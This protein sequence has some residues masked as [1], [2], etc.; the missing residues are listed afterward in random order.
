LVC[1]ALKTASLLDMT[2][3]LPWIAGRVLATALLALSLGAGAQPE[4]LHHYT[5]SI[6]EALSAISVHACFDGKPPLYLVSESLDAAAALDE[7]KADATRKQL[8]PNGAELKLGALP[9]GSC[10]SYRTDLSR[11]SR[12]NERDSEPLRRNGHDLITELGIW[13]WRPQSLEPDE[14]IEV[15]F[16][17]PPGISASAPWRPLVAADGTRAYRV[18]HSPYDWPAKVVFGHFQEMAIQVPG[19]VLRVALLDSSPTVEPDFVRQWL[20]RAATAV[21]TL[22]G[23][24]PVPHAQIV[25][26]PGTRGSEPVPWAYVLRGGAPAAHFFINQRRPLA[27]F[28]TD[29]TAVHELSHMLL[30]YVR[31]EDA[32]LSEGTASYYQNVLR[33]RAGMIPVPEA[34][35]KLH[36]GFRRGMK[37]MP[38]LTL[39]GA[40]ERMF[41]DG[42][43][44]RVYWEGA[45]MMLLADQRLRSRT[46]GAQSLD[47]ALARLHACCLSAATG[48]QARELFVKLDELTQTSVFGELYE[49]YIAS[50]AFPQVAE[51][52]RQLGLALDDE[53]ESIRL[54]DAAPQIAF[55]DAIMRAHRAEN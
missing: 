20:T 14:D 51:A 42:A 9:D 6:D 35:Q 15:R 28:L 34:W 45:A 22:Y 10:V 33:A 31:P 19:A 50:T 47:S 2:R 8:E 24:F 23:E 30:P 44:M 52:Y 54:L 12:R 13:F 37:S 26:V 16:E 5:V 39:A 41:R 27:E 46:G 1:F 3:T 21:T 55:R 7:V 4:R 32:W 53:G 29:W 49:A 11:V 38:G 25:V 36:S 43:F 17:L 48:W 18:G 40:T